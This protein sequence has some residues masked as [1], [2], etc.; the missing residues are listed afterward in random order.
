[1]TRDNDDSTRLD[2]GLLYSVRFDDFYSS[3]ENPAQEKHHVFCEGNRL[4]QRFGHAERFVI[5]ELGFGSGTGFLATAALWQATAPPGARLAFVSVEHYPLSR[6]LLRRYL[7]RFPQWHDLTERLLAPRPLE[8]MGRRLQQLM[9]VPVQR[10][11][12]DL[13]AALAE[14]AR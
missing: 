8:R 12:I 14:V 2:D 4:P 5:G 10:R 11:S 7:T 9:Q 6:E 3:R 1:M 13:Y